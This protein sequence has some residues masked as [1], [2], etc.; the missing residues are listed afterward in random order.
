MQKYGNI[1]IHNYYNDIV[2]VNYITPSRCAEYC[3]QKL[4]ISTINIT[5]IF[6]L[7]KKK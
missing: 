2:V 7:K 3:F 1:E 5:Y 4:F 6:Y